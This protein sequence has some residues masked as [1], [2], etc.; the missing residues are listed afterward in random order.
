MAGR[1]QQKTNQDVSAD[2]LMNLAFDYK[3]AGI[4]DDKQI[5]NG[6]TMEKKYSNDNN[7]HENMIDI[8]NMTK[9][10]GK[11]YVLDEKKRN[12]MQETIKTKVNGESNQDKVWK[13]YTE[14]LGLKERGERYSMN[15]TNRRNPN[16]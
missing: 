7:I 4:T 3:K 8:V 13:L 6:L 1:I 2:E 12:S 16:G 15:R 10:Y 14:T 11:D 9:D 5:E